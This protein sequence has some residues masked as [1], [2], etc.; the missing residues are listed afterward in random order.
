[1]E[2]TAVSAVLLIALAGFASALHVDAPSSVPQNTSWAF[3][4]ALDP[5]DSWT[6]AS[7]SIDDSNLLDVYSNGAISFDPFGGQFVLKAFLYDSDPNSTAGLTLY[8]S[9]FGLRNGAHKVSVWANGE[10]ES[11]A[12]TAF[13][14]MG[15]AD[16]NYFETRMDSLVDADSR[17]ASDL[18][19]LQMRVARNAL[20]LN[21]S[22]KAGVSS[23]GRRLDDVEGK[24]ASLS[25]A[26]AAGQQKKSNPASGLVDLVS[27]FIMPI[28][29]ALLAVI[30]LALVFGAV[31]FV[32]AQLSQPSNPY[33]RRDEYELPVKG[34]KSEIADALAESGKW[35][36]KKML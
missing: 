17:N 27:G 19:T 6:K 7:V 23:L 26:I 18:N 1:M 24:Q 16:R 21:N 15:D 9:H 25:S 4:V 28:G 10:G 2:K 12:V 11:V 35:K 34:E 32:K 33:P 31:L 30:A 5:T 3:S 22:V 8:V 14:P 29:Y 36:S 13:S 20:D